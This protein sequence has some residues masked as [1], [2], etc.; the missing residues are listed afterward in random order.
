MLKH[1]KINSELEEYT[2]KKVHKVDAFE[3]VCQTAKLFAN[4]ISLSLALEIDE[5]NT[6]SPIFRSGI[7]RCFIR[8]LNVINKRTELFLIF[9]DAVPGYT[10]ISFRKKATDSASSKV[11]RDPKKE[12][13]EMQIMDNVMKRFFNKNRSQILMLESNNL[14][15]A[16]FPVDDAKRHLKELE[17]YIT[18]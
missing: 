2:I 3:D 16:L 8:I 5:L 15:F 17:L 7:E 13:I 14:I 1:T 4:E 6:S 11:S 12:L 18:F 9:A 10:I